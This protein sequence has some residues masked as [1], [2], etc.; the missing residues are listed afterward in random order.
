[1]INEVYKFYKLL[2]L[3]I[4]NMN[5][6]LSLENIK[7]I[8]DEGKVETEHYAKV[9]VIMP[10][11]NSENYIETAIRSVL[12]QSWHNLEVIIVDDCSTDNT[13]KVVE[14][15]LIKDSRVKLLQTKVN[16]GPY[17]ARNL[18]LDVATGDFITCHD[19]DDWSHPQKIEKQVLHLVNNPNIMGNTSQQVRAST[20]LKFH[21]RGKPGVYIFDNMSSLMFRRKDVLEQLGY[22]DS[23]RFM[24]DGEFI[25]RFKKK[26]GELSIKNLKTGPLSFQRQTSTSL[27]GNKVFG[28]HGNLIGARLE[29]FE[30]SNYFH[31]KT[32]SLRYEFPQKLRPFAVPEP[33][34]KNKKHDSIERRHFDIILVSDFRLHGGSNMSNVEEIIAQKQLGIKVGLIQMNRYDLDPKRSFDSKVRNLVDGDQVQVIVFGEYVSCDLLIVRYPP[35]L[36]ERQRFIPDVK[37]NNIRVIINQPPQSDYGPNAVIRYDIKRANHYLQECFGKGA[38][39]CPIG[40]L[41]RDVLYEYHREELKEINLSKENWSNIIDVDKWERKSRPINSSKKIIGRHSRDNEVKWP[42]NPAELLGTYP[43][44]ED[45]EV[46]ILGGGETP[47]KVL[48]YLPDNWNVSDFGAIHP[49]KFLEKLDVFVYYTHSDWV[50]SFGRV[51]IEAMAVG[52]PVI[53][54]HSYRKLFEEAAIYAEPFEVKYYLEKLLNNENFYNEKVLEDS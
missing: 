38:I 24:A 11:Y 4:A 15:F 8:K 30:S 46:H 40:P 32:D 17:V 47:K 3:D 54:P 9:T 51:I 10:I 48:G 37:A 25:R 50:E 42:E 20:E 29:Y 26:F 52:V 23:V 44:S 31:S 36:Q 28:F 7:I 5:K 43:D 1:M 16:S 35:I 2:E 33:L 41:V 21:R 45:Y 39:W 53:L 18:A 14:S 19:A 49:K 13:F 12:S 22:W 34:I 27:T 6:E